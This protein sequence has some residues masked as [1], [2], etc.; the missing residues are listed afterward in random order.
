GVLAHHER[1]DGSGYPRGLKGRRIPIESRITSVADTLD[2]VECS[3]RYRRGAGAN[4]AF[5][6]IA[7]GRGTQFDPELVDLAL[8]PPITEKLARVQF[9]R[10]PGRGRRRPGE[11]ER[12][13][14]IS[15]R[16][17]SES[18]RSRGVPA[19]SRVD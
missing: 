7:S 10:R 1:W 16:W 5:D 8:M 18:L 4:A 14:E 13:P 12:V 11:R 9:T 17:R 15:F 19:V 2:A 6:I 3:R